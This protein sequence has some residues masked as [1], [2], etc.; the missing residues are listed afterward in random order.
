MQDVAD[1]ASRAIPLKVTARMDA[2]TTTQKG[3]DRGEVAVWAAAH[4][5]KDVAEAGHRVE[6]FALPAC[7]FWPMSRCTATS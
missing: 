4:L 3:P 1:A 2:G 5:A 6:T 7:C